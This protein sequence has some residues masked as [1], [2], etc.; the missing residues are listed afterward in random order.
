MFEV[1]ADFP[2]P[3]HRFGRSGF[4]Q[5]LRDMY[6]GDSVEIPIAKKTSIYGAAKAAGVKVRS[7][8]TDQGTVRVWRVDGPERPVNPLLSDGL[9]IFGDPLPKNNQR[10]A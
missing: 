4:T 7:R 2:I 5:T 6:R 1:S 8:S 3:E 9:D 10:S